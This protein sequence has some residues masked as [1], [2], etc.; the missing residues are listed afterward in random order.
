MSFNDFAFSH[1][2]GRPLA[3]I[4][5]C[6]ALSVSLTASVGCSDDPDEPPPDDSILAPPADGEGVQFVMH[7]QLE[8]GVE[9]EHCKFVKAPPEGLIVNRDEVRYTAGSHHFLLYETAYTEIPTAKEDGTPVDTSDVFDCSSGPTDG[10]DVTKLIGGSQNTDGHMLDFPEGI[11]VRIEPGRVLL[12]NAHYI[13]ASNERLEPEVRINLYSIS[14]D[15]LQVE[16]DLLFLYN[17][18]IRVPAR[19]EARARMRCPVYH[20]ITIVNVQS[21]MHARG[22]GYALMIEGQ[23]PF[24][25]N[26]K[27]EDVPV[28]NFMN[29]GGM[30][31]P[32]GARLDYYCEYTN[33][34]DVDVYQGP[35][36]TDEMCMVIG[37]YY[38]A[39][40]AIANCLDESDDEKLAAEWIGEGEAT[41]AATLICTV[42][43]F[44]SPEPLQA[45]TE[46]VFNSDPA[47]SAEVSETLNCVVA[48]QDPANECAD[49]IENCEMN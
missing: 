4:A 38:P 1:R 36:S 37:S 31:V 14:E 3:S 24:Y 33:T 43:A 10:W 22:T 5:L 45:L 47:K 48:S 34:Q 7:T 11:G 32:A 41:C 8:A 17:P 25:I 2:F 27:W 40:P 46:C 16:G 19:G 18:L 15:E 39:N 13:N 30:Q 42:A 44:S 12:M 49:L 6:A 9:A 35:R 29:E 26:D 21:H 20:D 28:A 23:E